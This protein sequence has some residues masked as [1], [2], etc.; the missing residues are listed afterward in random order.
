MILYN[1]KIKDLMIN[2]KNQNKK[3]KILLKK[4]KASRMIWI[5]LNK[6]M[7]N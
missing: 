7:R 2:S 4:N 6:S 3:I 1:K 5:N